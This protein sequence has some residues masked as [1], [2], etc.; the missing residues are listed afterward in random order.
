MANKQTVKIKICEKKVHMGTLTISAN[1]P[2]DRGIPVFSPE[3]RMCLENIPI[4]DVFDAYNPIQYCIIHSKSA[5]I[6]LLEETEYSIKFEATHAFLN[7]NNISVLNKLENQ[8]FPD[9]DDEKTKSKFTIERVSDNLWF[10]NLNFKSYAG[11]IF[12]DISAD[13][14]EYE[15]NVGVRS[16]KLDYNEEYSEMISDLAEYSSG[17]LFKTNALL[18]QSH[19]L[20]KNKKILNMNIICC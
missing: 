12:I 4:E 9:E 11:N 18:Y 6:Y 13:E 17:V 15:L 2:F 1:A 5:H 16:K 8:E 3:K 20:A 19:E 7:K 14:F 10:G